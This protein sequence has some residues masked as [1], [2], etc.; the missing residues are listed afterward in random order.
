MRIWGTEVINLCHSDLFLSYRDVNSKT[1]G[2]SW[3]HCLKLS[4]LHLA[5][6][7]RGVTNCREW[8]LRSFWLCV[9]L[10]TPWDTTLSRVVCLFPELPG[11]ENSERSK[12]LLKE[13]E[14]EKTRGVT[15]RRTNCVRFLFGQTISCAKEKINPSPSLEEGYALS[16]WKQAPVKQI[17]SH[18]PKIIRWDRDAEEWKQECETVK[19]MNIS[20]DGGFHLAWQGLKV[21]LHQRSHLRMELRLRREG[22]E[23]GLQTRKIKAR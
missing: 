14:R 6:N 13:E 5:L 7:D 19:E 21:N 2:N 16:N 23:E 1:K 4:Y 18:K 20:S 12:W 11:R 9:C 22:E 10:C 3:G 17:T 8:W 15:E